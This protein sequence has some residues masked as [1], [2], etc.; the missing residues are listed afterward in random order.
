MNKI[1]K[2]KWNLVLRG[3]GNDFVNELVRVAPVD[4]GNLRL[5]IRYEVDNNSINIVMPEYAFYLEFGTKPHE[6]RVKNA[7]VLSD[8][9][10]FFGKSVLHPGTEAQPFIRSTINTK[11]RQ[12][13]YNNIKEVFVDGGN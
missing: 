8:G 3:I 2:N 10:I 9:K 11:L 7:S 1:F 5:S 13:V 12:I 4:T 6:I